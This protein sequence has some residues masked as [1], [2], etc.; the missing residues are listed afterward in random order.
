M[1][2][3]TPYILLYRITSPLFQSK[4]PSLQTRKST[5]KCSNL[6]FSSNLGW[7]I[8]FSASKTHKKSPCRRTTCSDMQLQLFVVSAFTNALHLLLFN[9]FC[10]Q[11]APVPEKEPRLSTAL[12]RVSVKEGEQ[13]RAGDSEREDVWRKKMQSMAK[14]VWYFTQVSGSDEGAS[15]QKQGFRPRW[16]TG[17]IPCWPSTVVIRT[18]SSPQAGHSSEMAPRHSR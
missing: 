3:S 14:E 5:T 16:D 1:N 11:L 4:M 8:G 15:F 13:G 2:N 17:H 12:T 10:L 6:F 7:E 9:I 18:T